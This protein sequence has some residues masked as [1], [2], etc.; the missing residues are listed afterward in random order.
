MRISDWSSDVCSSD[1]LAD[2]I[3]QLQ[4][5][6]ERRGLLVI[7]LG[8]QA[9]EFEAALL[10]AIEVP[11]GLPHAVLDAA[12]VGVGHLLRVAAGAEGVF[13]RRLGA[14]VNRLS[15]HLLPPSRLLPRRV[16]RT[17]RK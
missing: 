15:A 2:V 7:A 12:R 13:L 16:A 6:L 8:A 17:G 4:R 3:L 14:A 1:L 9:A 10:V 5:P 11:E